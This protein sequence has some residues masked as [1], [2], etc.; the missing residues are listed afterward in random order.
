MERGANRSLG[1]VLGCSGD[2]SKTVIFCS[3][4]WSKQDKETDEL[5]VFV[6]NDVYFLS[7][8]ELLLQQHLSIRTV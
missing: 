8:Q 3:V 1:L 5:Y 6:Y 2:L 7:T 4:C